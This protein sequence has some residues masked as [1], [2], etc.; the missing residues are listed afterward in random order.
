MAISRQR[1]GN[2]YGERRDNLGSTAPQQNTIQRH[3]QAQTSLPAKTKDVFESG[4]QHKDQMDKFAPNANFKGIRRFMGGS[5]T[6][7]E[8]KMDMVAQGRISASK[9]TAKAPS[10]RKMLSFLDMIASN[11][12]LSSSRKVQEYTVQKLKERAGLKSKA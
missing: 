10:D 6:A 4:R 11:E 5:K 8:A 3:Q 2:T 7:T 9:T 12:H 1:V